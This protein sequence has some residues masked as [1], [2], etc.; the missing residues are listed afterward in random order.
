MR[1]EHEAQR[2]SPTRV[3]TL[4]AR[5]VE[6]NIA[7]KI[8]LP[9]GKMLRRN[10]E[11]L[12][13]LPCCSLSLLRAICVGFNVIEFGFLSRCQE[14]DLKSSRI[15]IVLLWTLTWFMLNRCSHCRYFS[16]SAIHRKSPEMSLNLLYLLSQ[17]KPRLR[18]Q[19]KCAIRSL[20][21]S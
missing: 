14:D 2:A 1:A 16:S 11:M 15:H 19:T 21:P 7:A 10:H 9:E 3:K 13:S 8:K 18:F 12:A 20:T 4:A 17:L 6:K 5:R